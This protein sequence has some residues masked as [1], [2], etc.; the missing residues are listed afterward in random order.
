MWR[1]DS[2]VLN[3][4]VLIDLEIEVEDTEDILEDVPEDQRTTFKELL[5]TDNGYGGKL[6]NRRVSRVSRVS[7]ACCAQSTFSKYHF[8]N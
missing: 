3:A 8:Q 6:F 4:R 5:L 1:G 2:P 7:R